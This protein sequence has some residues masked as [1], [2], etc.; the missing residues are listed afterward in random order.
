MLSKPH[1]ASTNIEDGH[2]V[3]QEH[4]S[5]D[6]ERLNASASVAHTNHAVLDSKSVADEPTV[7]QNEIRRAD[8][9]D[10]ASD[11]DP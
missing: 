9:E 3:L 7:G 4:V 1:H 11:L 10:G 5:E 2:N 6:G 8:V